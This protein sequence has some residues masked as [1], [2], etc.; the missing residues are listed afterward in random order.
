MARK[1][2]TFSKNPPALRLFIRD[3]A[4]TAA[5]PRKEDCVTLKEGLGIGHIPGFFLGIAK[6]I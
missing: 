4:V 2:V 5:E 3:E 1:V 6:S